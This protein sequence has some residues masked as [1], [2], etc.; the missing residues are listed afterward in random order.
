VQEDNPRAPAPAASP[1]RGQRFF[2]RPA[3]VVVRRHVDL[4]VQGLAGAGDGF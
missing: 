2:D 1:R 4:E 3:H